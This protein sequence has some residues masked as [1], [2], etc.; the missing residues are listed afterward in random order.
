[1]TSFCN[2]LKFSLLFCFLL[3]KLMRSSFKKC[4]LLEQCLMKVIY[5]VLIIFMMISWVYLVPSF[6]AF[7]GCCSSFANFFVDIWVY[8]IFDY[9]KILSLFTSL[10]CV[11]IIFFFLRQIVLLLVTVLMWFLICLFFCFFF[12]YLKKEI[13]D[14]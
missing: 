1:M 6:L 8:L 7:L 10:F 4:F 5:L 9:L 11:F 12:D 13:S 14:R 3:M 2:D